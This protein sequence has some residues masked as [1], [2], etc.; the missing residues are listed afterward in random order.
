MR[1]RETIVV[2]GGLLTQQVSTFV[3]GILIARSLGANAFGTLATLKGLTTFLAIVTPLGLDLSLLKHGPLYRRRPSELRVISIAL[4]ALSGTLNLGLLILVGLCVGPWLQT[5]YASIHGFTYFAVLSMAA[6]L[7]TADIQISGAL[8]RV[9]NAVSL[10]AIAVNYGQP[11]LRL[12]MSVLAVGLGGGVASIL[13]V[14]VVTAAMTFAALAWL[15]PRRSAP[16]V[17]MPN[18]PMVLRGILSESLWMALLLLVGQTMRFVDIIFLSAM[19]TTEITG[20]YTAMSNV[21]QLILIYPGAISQTLGPTIASLHHANDYAGMSAVLRDYFRKASLLGGYLFGG[22]AV[23]G[24]QLDVVFGKS[25]VFSWQLASLLAFGWYVSATL[26][27]LSYALSMTGRHKQDFVI[28]IVGTLLLIVGLRFMIPSLKEIGA[29]LAVAIAF[30]VVNAIRVYVV[31]RSLPS[32]PIRLSCLA[33][34]LCFAGLAA[35]CAGIG[36]CLAGRGLINLSIQCVAYSA[37]SVGL[38][39][40][41]FAT[42]PERRQ[43][44]GYLQAGRRLCA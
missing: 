31:T 15:D 10:Y 41:M 4:R 1:L 32:N 37:L 44:I 12:A 8:F 20:A 23:F 18:L 24:S 35:C 7:F 11:V 19:T 39:V 17:R 3:T 6:L 34:P 43:L 42:R 40:S 29:A 26:G 27:P 14:N 28:L 30:V 33:Y 21:A 25:F 2:S 16:L 13:W 36:S 5:T 22:I 38:Y 9:D